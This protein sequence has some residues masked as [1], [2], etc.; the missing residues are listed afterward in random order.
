MVACAFL[1]LKEKWKWTEYPIKK[2]RD[3]ES[4][5]SRFSGAAVAS[6]PPPD[7]SERSLS[8]SFSI[9]FHPTIT[10]LPVVR[11]LYLHFYKTCRECVN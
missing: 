5:E 10:S 9:W 2:I 7:Y 4:A 8:L 1:E 6:F 11:L 3:T